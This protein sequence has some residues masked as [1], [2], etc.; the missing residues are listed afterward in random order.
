MLSKVIDVI[1]ENCKNC[2]ACISV[3]PSKFCNDCSGDYVKINDDLCIGC[4]ECLSAC[5]WGAR[6]IK[7]DIGIFFEA[8]NRR[9]KILAIIS[10]AVVSSFPYTYLNLNG[11]LKSIGISAIFD[12]GFGSELTIQSYIEHIEKTSPQTV[13][14]QPCPAVVSYIELYKPNLLPYLAPVDSPMLHMIKMIKEYHP[15]YRKHKM[16]IISP[17]IAKKRELEETG[18]GD[19]NITM[20]SLQDYITD[21]NINLETFTKVDY[22]NPIEEKATAFSQTNGILETAVRWNPEL[23]NK[24]RKIEGPKTVYEY[25]NALEKE[26][27]RANSPLIVDCTNCEK[28]CSGGTG[29]KCRNMP[30]DTLDNH[31]KSRKAQEQKQ[32]LRETQTKSLANP[33]SIQQEILKYAAKHWKA[34]LYNRKYTNRSNNKIVTTPPSKKIQEIYSSMLKDANE[35]HKNCSACGY[36]NCKDMAIAIYNGL[37]K[38]QNCHYFKS[39]Q[40]KNNAEKQKKIIENFQNLLSD[41]FN[42]TKL[43]SK[44]APIIESIENLS[45]QTEI[46]SL[47]AAIEAVKAGEA[48]KGFGVV[49]KEVSKLAQKS[50]AETQKIYA[51]LAELQNNLDSAISDFETK[52]ETLINEDKI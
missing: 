45:F 9:E 46:L 12:I 29:T 21:H 31:T 1:P 22:D 47:N 19:F 34:G 50:N 41:E 30:V 3:C 11:W 32:Y 40:L 16:A 25:I 43:L 8:I 39:K 13:I 2:H 51:S 27:I 20:S 6:V 48:G 5:T 18:Y 36:G 49:A 28:G 10:P 38:S 44:F 42:S 4:G 15:E 26:I 7:D 37:N 33:N 24:I 52:L 23:K 14:S 35:D 17:C